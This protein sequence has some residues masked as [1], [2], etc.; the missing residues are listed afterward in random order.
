LQTRQLLLLLLRM[1]LL[2]PPL[3][4]KLLRKLLSKMLRHYRPKR[5]HMLWRRKHLLLRTLMR[6]L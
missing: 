2:Q 6:K 4:R 5:L 1:L 3:L